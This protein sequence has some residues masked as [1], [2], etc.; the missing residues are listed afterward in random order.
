MKGGAAGG[1]GGGENSAAEMTAGEE[2]SV[3]EPLAA[4]GMEL[5]ETGGGCDI[6]VPVAAPVGLGGA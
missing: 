4:P 5:A 6:I 3:E 1:G 2:Q